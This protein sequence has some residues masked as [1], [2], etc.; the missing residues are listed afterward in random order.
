MIC[1]SKCAPIAIRSTRARRKLWIPAAASINSARS[2]GRRRKP[3]S[4]ANRSL[5]GSRGPEVGVRGM[6]SPFIKIYERGRHTPHPNL[7]P[8]LPRKDLLDGVSAHLE[9]SQ[10]AL[11]HRERDVVDLVGSLDARSDRFLYF[12]GRHRGTAKESLVLIAA[13]FT[14]PFELFRRFHTF[15]HH[16]EPQAVSQRDDCLD[17][18]RIG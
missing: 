17:D 18:G 15:G 7:L 3:S 14:Q 12:G 16:L 11:G 10:P 4:P 13:H 8:L 2:T 1:R 9:C 6:P 5:R